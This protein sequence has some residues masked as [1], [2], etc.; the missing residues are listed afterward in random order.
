M[1]EIFNEPSRDEVIAEAIAWLENAS[2][3]KGL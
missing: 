1:H 2:N 3:C